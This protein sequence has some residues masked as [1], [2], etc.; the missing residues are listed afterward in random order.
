MGLLGLLFVHRRWGPTCCWHMG[1]G[2]A[3]IVGS[4]LEVGA[5]WD[6]CWYI[7]GGGLLRLL[8]VHGRLGPTGIVVGTWQVGA[9]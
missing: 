9:D 2:A 6:C 4:V 3:V 1:S 5:Y 7:E 8:L